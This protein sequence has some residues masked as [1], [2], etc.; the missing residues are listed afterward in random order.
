MF[1][2]AHFGTIDV[3]NLEEYYE[4]EIPLADNLVA[5]DL[6]FEA[7]SVSVESMQMV[8]HLLQ[9]L[10]DIDSENRAHLYDTFH[11]K[12]ENTV[13]FYLHHHLDNLADEDLA[14]LVNRRNSPAEQATQ[15]LA[16]IHVVHI[17]FYPDSDELISVFDY[18]IGEELTNYLLVVGRNPQ[19]DICYL[20]LES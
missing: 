9:N 16:N 1:T 3:Q 19:N 8:Q 12:E 11:N 20:T 14:P 17:S 18:S 13:S 2:L 7:E 5:V 10:A 4:I 15:L 6:N